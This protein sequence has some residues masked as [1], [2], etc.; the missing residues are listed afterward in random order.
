MVKAKF[1]GDAENLHFQCAEFHARLGNVV[2]MPN[3]RW[4]AIGAEGKQG[5]FTVIENDA[6]AFPA[7][8]TVGPK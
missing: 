2:H 1:N 3:E 5:L 6:D 8:R 4:D 7:Q